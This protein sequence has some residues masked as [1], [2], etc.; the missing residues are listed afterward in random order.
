MPIDATLL[1]VVADIITDLSA[2]AFA[3]VVIFPLN[4]P[5]L[6]E[7]ETDLVVTHFLAGVFGLVS[8]WILRTVVV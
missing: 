8:A 5:R 2:A 4:K 6:W 7:E 3:V 1:G